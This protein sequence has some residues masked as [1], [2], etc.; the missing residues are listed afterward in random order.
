M[1]V[2]GIY[3]TLVNYI[4]IS[5]TKLKHND[6]R[7]GKRTLSV[8]LG[9]RASALLLRI[10]KEAIFPSA[11]GFFTGFV[12]VGLEFELL[13]LGFFCPSFEE[14]EVW[15]VLGAGIFDTTS[16]GFFFLTLSALCSGLWLSALAGLFVSEESAAG[17]EQ[18]ALVAVAVGSLSVLL[19]GCS[20]H[21]VTVEAGSARG[22]AGP[23]VLELSAVSAFFADLR[24]VGE[25]RFAILIVRSLEPREE[26][27]LGCLRCERSKS[28]SAA[29]SESLELESSELEM[30]SASPIASA[31]AKPESP[32]ATVRRREFFVLRV[33]GVSEPF[34]ASLSEPLV[35]RTR[36]RRAF[37][38]AGSRNIK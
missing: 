26:L 4:S 22:A 2:F 6:H 13:S 8:T 12:G 3:C 19:V 7:S 24:S 1:L 10:R 16:L 37:F 30:D 14:L 5:I 15:D 31:C 29:C 28:G 25:E 11:A 23:E 20:E 32:L 34:A 38:G 27:H 33:R 36:F 9:M 18:S 35:A 21:S 17:G